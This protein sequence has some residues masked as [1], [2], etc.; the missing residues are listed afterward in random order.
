MPASASS[1]NFAELDLVFARSRRRAAAKRALPR[2]RR[3]VTWRTVWSVVLA[4][5]LLGFI[6]ETT[7]V[8]MAPGRSAASKTPAAT[9][10][11]CGIPI[12]FVRAFRT[13]SR[14]TGLAMPLLAAVAWEES[15]MN[16]HAVSRA[17]AYGLLQLMPG[18]ARAVDSTDISPRANILAGARYLSAMLGRFGGDLELAL[19][20]YNT[21]PTAVQKA[22]AAPT[23]GT[24]R[25][26]KNIEARAASLTE[27]A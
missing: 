5:A 11:S 12:P 3:P 8:E 2:R 17:G 13:A 27:C 4:V 21:G 22:G 23:I 26:V 18:T 24:L 19:A 14:E 6:A 7:R 1:H 20:A 9:A 25:Y 10:S 15:R 16:P